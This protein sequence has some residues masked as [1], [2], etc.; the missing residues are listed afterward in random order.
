MPHTEGTK[1]LHI[2]NLEDNALDAELLHAALTDG[3]LACEILQVQT[4]ADYIAALKSGNFDLILADYALPSFDGLSALKIAQ[5]ACPEVPFVLVSG[6]LGEERAIEAL[7]S[8][9]TDYVLKQQLERLVP[10]VQRAMREADQQT[11]RMR[12]E[13]ELRESEKRFRGTFEQAAVGIAHVDADGRWLRVN[14]R[15][16]EIVGYSRE[17]LL[18]KTFQKITHP[19]DLDADLEKVRQLLAGEI[20]TYSMEKRYFRKDGSIV[21]INLTSSLMREPSGAPNYFIGVIE[22][23]TARKRA[24]EEVKT[25]HRQQATVAKLGLRALA[26]NDLKVVMDEAVTLVART[27]G[28]EYCK[29]LELLPEGGE[30]LLRAGVGWEE[31]LVGNATVGAGNDSQA[32]YTL[33]SEEPVIVEDLGAEQRF[34]GP[35]LLHEHGVVSGMSV[36]IHGRDGPFG[37]LGVHTKNRRRFTEDDVN[38]LQTVA[39]VLCTAI[40]RKETEEALYKVREAERKRIARDLH[41]GALQD[42]TYALAETQLIQ[43]MSGEPELDSRLER[44]VEALKRSGR[45]LHA[46]VYDLRLEEERDRTFLQQ[47]ESLVELHHEM[48]PECEVRLSVEGGFP[49]SPLPERDQ[50]LLRI[51]QEALSNT[52]KHSDARNVVVSLGMEGDEIFWAEVKDDGRG[53]DLDTPSG[54]GLKSMRERARALGGNLKIESEP[55]KN[56]KVRFEVA[57][58]KEDSETPESEEE[59]R[60]LLV[61]DHTSYRDA[62]TSVFEREPGFEVVGQ[63]GSLTQARKILKG[64]SLAVDVAIVD[65]G[66]PDGYGGELIKELRE[67]NP[68]AQALVLSASLDKSEVAGAI[69]AGAAGVLHKSVGMEEVVQ[70]VRRLKAGETLLPPEEVVE[71]LRFA[72]YHREQEQ[73]A[74]QAIAQ[75]TPR[76]KEVLQALAEGLESKQIAERL[77]IS[78]LT[79]RNHVMSIL[80]KLGVHSRLQAVVFA[81]RFDIVKI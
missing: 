4:R 45:E 1:A 75:L 73:E 32:G 39:N 63:A 7:K 10:A 78:V 76:E 36:I 42:L 30:L 68:Q 59:T 41:D 81:L 35:P 51:L 17:E 24:E 11:K 6:V 80:T 48:T 70:A 34:S 52:R 33:L 72:I 79:E 13:M 58:Y 57:L 15:L 69:E 16:C 29:V 74:H 66:L 56:T 26:E 37:V 38:F 53:F 47:L 25:Y 54:V 44:T 40:E 28:V 71:L 21:W 22:D 12:A 65:L 19:D 23:I 77:H 20:E 46:A 62:A 3:G 50:E 18:Q 64:G 8:G 49:S 5:E 43:E 14:Q 27:L 55:G 31:G 67:I 60:I 2:L 61:E 9:A